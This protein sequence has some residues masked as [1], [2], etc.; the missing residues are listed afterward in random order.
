VASGGSLLEEAFAGAARSWPALVMLGYVSLFDSK[1]HG[2]SSTMLLALPAAAGFVFRARIAPHLKQLTSAIPTHLRGPVLAGLPMAALYLTRWKGTQSDGAA[3]LTA[4]IPLALS[5]VLASRRQQLDAR[6]AGFYRARN[7]IL[8]KP[9]RMAS[10]VVVPTVLA[11]GV[12]HG[13]LND[14]GALFGEQTS[15]SNTP[16]GNGILISSMLT[17]IIVFL[18]LNERTGDAVDG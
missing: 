6:L 8:P 17:A 3:Y 16:T 7:R 18:L 15:T 11:F 10:V 9:V 5:F 4:G 2:S 12:A 1:L 13:D 14:I